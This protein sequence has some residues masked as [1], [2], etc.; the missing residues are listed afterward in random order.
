MVKPTYEELLEENKRYGKRLAKMA[1]RVAGALDIML[2]WESML[3][4]DGRF[5]KRVTNFIEGKL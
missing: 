2:D 3:H 1:E 5:L 4:R